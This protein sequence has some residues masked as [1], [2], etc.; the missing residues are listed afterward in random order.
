VAGDAVSPFPPNT[1]IATKDGNTASISPGP[2]IDI[3]LIREAVL[4]LHL[5]A[6][7]DSECR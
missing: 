3:A 5:E 2:T 4:E 6:G 1:L 7:I